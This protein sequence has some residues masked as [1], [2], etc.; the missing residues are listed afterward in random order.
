MTERKR[1]KSVGESGEQTETRGR[2][3]KPERNEKP[4]RDKKPK[5]EKKHGRL[6]RC[7]SAFTQNRVLGNTLFQAALLSLFLM[8]IIEGCGR[9]SPFGALT[10]FVENPPAFLF[11]NLIIFASMSIVGLVK[12]RVFCRTL[13]FF[14]W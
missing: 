2:S 12:R 1:K 5:R 8:F 14:L 7:V 3:N 9:K 11:N 4:K 13:I 10:F 6:Y